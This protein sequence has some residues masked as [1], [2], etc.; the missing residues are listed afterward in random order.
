MFFIFLLTSNYLLLSLYLLLYTSSIAS[1]NLKQF[2]LQCCQL[3]VVSLLPGDSV[4]PVS[5][6]LQPDL[7][8]L[9]ANMSL[10]HHPSGHHERCLSLE[11]T[12][13]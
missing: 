2:V 5:D 11:E 4:Q 10:A 13:I 9:Q 12:H 8:G 6:F 7:Q 3:Q 1:A